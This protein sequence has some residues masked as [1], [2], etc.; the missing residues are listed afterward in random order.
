MS[1]WRA[2]LRFGCCGTRLGERG[3]EGRPEHFPRR[4]EEGGQDRPQDEPH[5]PK[6]HEAAERREEDE[7][8]VHLRV[9]SDEP[10]PEHIVHAA[11]DEAQNSGSPI[12][13]QTSP[14]VI[15]MIAAGTHTSAP[16]TP[17]M[18]DKTV[19]TVPQ[20]IAPS[21]PTAQ[22]ATPPS[23]PCATPIRIVPLS[24][25]RVTDTN[26]PTMRVLSASVSGR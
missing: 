16:P 25:A 8:L 17:G 1:E 5:R 2:I 9:L 10:R 13:R 23:R 14:V 3:A 11:H 4:D 19:I 26:F 22:N 6:E 20:K 7:E 18:I 15:R 24:V 12:P 21:I